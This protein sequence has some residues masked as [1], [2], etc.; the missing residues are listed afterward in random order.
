MTEPVGLRRSDCISPPTGS[1]CR[2]PDS[3][4]AT[5]CTAAHAR[6]R[7]VRHIVM[8]H[9][10]FVA[11]FAPS[12]RVRVSGLALPPQA[13]AE[14]AIQQAAHVRRTSGQRAA[15]KLTQLTPEER[16]SLRWLRPRFYRLRLRAGSGLRLETASVSKRPAVSSDYK[17]LDREL[18]ARQERSPPRTRRDFMTDSCL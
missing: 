16:D 8:S 1:L 12:P 15:V 4:Y 10:S 7:R 18:R 13:F 14:T 9:P 5:T 2:V 6:P 17:S 3:G 11:C